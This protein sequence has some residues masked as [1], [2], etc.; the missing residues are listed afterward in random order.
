MNLKNYSK[1]IDMIY[2]KKKLIVYSTILIKV[3]LGQL[4]HKHN[5]RE[6]PLVRQ[7]ERAEGE[8]GRIFRCFRVS[9]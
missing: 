8:F 2:Q 1:N 7:G 3:T 9:F 6:H 4:R 5:P